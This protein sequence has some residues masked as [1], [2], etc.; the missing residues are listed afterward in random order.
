MASSFS[1]IPKEKLLESIHI[2][3]PCKADWNSMTGDEKVRFCGQCKLNVYNLS[4]MTRKEATDLVVAKEGKLCIRFY[5]RSD[6]TVI[7]QNCPVGLRKLRDRVC[8]IAA[9]IAGLVWFIMTMSHALAK[10]TKSTAEKSSKRLLSNPANYFAPGW[11]P[12]AQQSSGNAIAEEI[13][14]FPDTITTE[15]YIDPERVGVMGGSITIISSHTF[16]LEKFNLEE[17]KLEEPKSVPS[18]SPLE[19]MP[20][21]LLPS[22]SLSS[23]PFPDLLPSQVLF[24]RNA[25]TATGLSRHQPI[26]NTK[27]GIVLKS[28]QSPTP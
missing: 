14:Y 18:L 23:S 24:P 16:E 25:K 5:K 28:D 12:R 1:D 26:E 7:T 4:E 27:T 10:D 21:S 6:G 2:A 8:K 19:A 15:N 9:T 22:L 11:I 3:A 20:P 13:K 17:L